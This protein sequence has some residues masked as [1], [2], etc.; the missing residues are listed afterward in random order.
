MSRRSAIRSSVEYVFILAYVLYPSGNLQKMRAVGTY[1]PAKR[2]R[3]KAAE[4]G[5]S[6]EL[7]VGY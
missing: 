1:E 5:R 7:H 3:E 6:R 2:Q 4:G